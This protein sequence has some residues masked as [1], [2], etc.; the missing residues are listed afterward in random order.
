MSNELLAFELREAA[1]ALGSI[2]GEVTT[3]EILNAIFARFC[4][5]K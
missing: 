2:C 5:G 3:D 1:A 4:I